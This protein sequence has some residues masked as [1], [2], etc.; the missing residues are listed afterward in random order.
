MVTCV[1]VLNV[2]SSWASV[3][4]VDN[5]L[6]KSYGCLNP[7]N[8]I[9]TTTIA[10]TFKTK[11]IRLELKG[12]ILFYFF[13]LNKCIYCFFISAQLLL[14]LCIFLFFKTLI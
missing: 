2:A 14:L 7:R 11:L 3:P 4:F 9:I 1:P 13:T 8:N 6:S 12:Y 10:S 5:M